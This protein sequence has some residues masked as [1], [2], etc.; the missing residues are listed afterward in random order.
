MCD[1]NPWSHP[2][3][4]SRC[5][6]I[7]LSKSGKG[8]T[9]PQAKTTL[10]VL[11]WC[12]M[13]FHGSKAVPRISVAIAEI[14]DRFFGFAPARLSREPEDALLRTNIPYSNDREQRSSAIKEY[15]SDGW[16]FKGKQFPNPRLRYASR[17]DVARIMQKKEKHDARLRPLPVVQAPAPAPPMY[18]LNN[19]KRAPKKVFAAKMV[20]R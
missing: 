15:C 19:K 4:L 8:C 10:D 20:V 3:V 13:H 6:P 9:K 14:Q 11:K 2:I 12:A 7:C 18:K 17:V 5:E 1:R 16:S